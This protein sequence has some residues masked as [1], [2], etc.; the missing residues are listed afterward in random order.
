MFINFIILSSL[1]VYLE[2]DFE[3]FFLDGDIFWGYFII[4]SGNIYEGFFLVEIVG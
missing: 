1:S 3:I 2:G 4:V